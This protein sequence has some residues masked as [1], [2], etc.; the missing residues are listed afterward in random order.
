MTDFINIVPIDVA[1]HIANQ[2]DV[3]SFPNLLATCRYFN[4]NTKVSFHNKVCDNIEMLITHIID[5]IIEYDQFIF[6]T[7]NKYQVTKDICKAIFKN[8]LDAKTAQDMDFLLTL[9]EHPITKIVEL[10]DGNEQD[11]HLVL[12]Q[13]SS[14]ETLEE[15]FQKQ[16]LNAIQDCLFTKEYNVEFELLDNNKDVKYTCGVNVN[17][18]KEIPELKV[19]M[20][21]EDSNID[22]CV[23][24]FSENIDD[25]IKNAEI[26]CDGEVA[27][28]ATKESIKG[29]TRYICKVFGN[30]VF[31]HQLTDDGVQIQICNFLNQPFDCCEFYRVIVS[32][33]TKTQQASAKIADLIMSE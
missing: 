30:G 31:T 21:D 20:I 13:V 23:N 28:T 24:P 25:Y 10:V 11:V 6:D 22:L 27:F 32:S 17:L 8:I 2:L 15:E 14:E 1:I 29:L 33:M 18:Q 3:K 4:T 19:K 26:T 7:E 16:V 12:N 9:L 5:I